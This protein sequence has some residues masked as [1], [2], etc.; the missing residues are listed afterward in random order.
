MLFLLLCEGGKG[1]YLASP[2]CFPFFG[3]RGLYWYGVCS[4][5]GRK[6]I[7]FLGPPPEEMSSLLF[8]F[9]VFILSALCA[10]ERR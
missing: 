8:L 1:D 2:P 9:A 4:K 6:F 3:P 5:E 10:R 7:S